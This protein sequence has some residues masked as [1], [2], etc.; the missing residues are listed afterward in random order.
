M[1]LP[2]EQALLKHINDFCE[3]NAVSPSRFGEEAVNDRGLVTRL[4]NGRSP[5]LKHARKIYTFMAKWEAEHE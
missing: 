3:R 4:K 2:T 1:Q 5:S